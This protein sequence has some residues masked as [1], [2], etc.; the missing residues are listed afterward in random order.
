MSHLHS[1]VEAL[2]P[3]VMVFGDGLTGNQPHAD[4]L[5]LIS[6]LQP[7]ELGEINFCYLSPWSM[8]FYMPGG[9]DTFTLQSIEF[10]HEASWDQ[11]KIET[12]MSREQ[13]R[14]SL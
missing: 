14:V 3:N 5:T 2:A 4:T 1:C 10:E 13:G 8:V 11:R 7:A 6:N 12:I 9:T